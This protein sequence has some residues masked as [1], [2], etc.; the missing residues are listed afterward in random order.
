MRACPEQCEVKMAERGV[1]V[2]KDFRPRLPHEERRASVRY[3]SLAASACCGVVDR[4]DA[5]WVGHVRDVSSLG[6]GLILP[7][8]LE[9]GVLLEID[10]GR[11]PR[12]LSRTLLARVVHVQ[13][14]DEN[15]WVVGCA[16]TSELANDELKRF[17]AERVRSPRADSRRWVRY[18]CNIETVCST[19]LTT[20]GEQ[21]AAR[22]LNVSPGGIGLV[23][24]C[25]FETGTMLSFGLPEDGGLPGHRRLVRVVRALDHSNGDWFLGCEF[26]EQLSPAELRSL[27]E[28]CAPK[29][30]V[31][32]AAALEGGGGSGG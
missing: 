31:A 12:D 10:L 6:V 8:L 19:C 13:R 21:V 16:F 23:I 28:G 15:G 4:T 18:P 5:S 20:P 7:V 3:P 29:E 30:I 26:A 17:Q 27:R 1:L 2:G 24:P 25:Q 9:P 14:E 32:A 22:I 11:P